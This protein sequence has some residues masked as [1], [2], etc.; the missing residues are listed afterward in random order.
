MRERKPVQT[1]SGIVSEFPEHQRQFA[2]MRTGSA[3]RSSDTRYARCAGAR[4]PRSQM[5]GFAPSATSANLPRVTEISNVAYTRK[6]TA[7]SRTRNTSA[8]NANMRRLVRKRPAYVGNTA[9]PASAARRASVMKIKC[10]LSRICHF[11]AQAA[12]FAI[13]EIKTASS[14]LHARPSSSI[15]PRTDA[16]RIACAKLAALGA[17]VWIGVPALMAAFLGGF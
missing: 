10:S 13:A 1:L 11:A 3:R 17:A 8:R 5:M 14:P 6:S 15:V 16:E 7:S 4:P 9:Y 12:R 2:A